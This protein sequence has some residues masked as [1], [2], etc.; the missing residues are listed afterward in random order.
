LH[1]QF[2]QLRGQ[3]KYET[4]RETILQRDERLAG[5]TNPMLAR[6]G[7]MSEAAQ[8]SG[9]LVGESWRCPFS[10]PRVAKKSEEPAE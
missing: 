10:D 6:H 8:Y 1:D 2:E 5:S 4:I 7:D 9:R 3:G